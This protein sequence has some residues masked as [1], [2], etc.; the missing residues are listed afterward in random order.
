MTLQDFF[1]LAT[2]AAG[3]VFVLIFGLWWL[4]KDRQAILAKLEEERNERIT[5]LEKHVDECAKDRMRIQ[6]QLDVL[7]ER[8][9]EMETQ[10]R[11][12]LIQLFN[13]HP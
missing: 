7:Q 10:I 12:K 3:A 4:D 1:Q 5:L 2:G 6:N 8:Y 9:T 13:T 11:E